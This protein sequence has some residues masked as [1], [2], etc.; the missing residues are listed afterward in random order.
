MGGRAVRSWV[1][2]RCG[3]SDG[4]A[5]L[6]TLSV[7]LLAKL[8]TLPT[9]DALWAGVTSSVSVVAPWVL[10]RRVGDAWIS[11]RAATFQRALCS[12]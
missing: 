3:E 5:L 1:I 11:Y 7:V 9:T 10:S 2:C 6:R 8:V 12:L 4:E